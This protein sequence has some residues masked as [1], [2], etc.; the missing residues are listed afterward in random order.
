MYLQIVGVKTNV[1]FLMQLAMHEE[2]QRGNVHTDFIPQ[3]EKEIFVKREPSHEEVCA[4]L[5]ST[6]HQASKQK[7]DGK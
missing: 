4:A 1:K 6:I 7:T 3:H 5:L 2:F